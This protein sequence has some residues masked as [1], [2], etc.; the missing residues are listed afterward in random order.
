MSNLKEDE[1][2]LI[3]IYIIIFILVISS[4]TIL[5]SIFYFIFYSFFL[6]CKIFKLKTPNQVSN[7]SSRVVIHE[8]NV[9]PTIDL[10]NINILV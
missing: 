10:N 8:P 9:Q 4:L 3:S 7:I 1:N 5:F 2:A 6:N